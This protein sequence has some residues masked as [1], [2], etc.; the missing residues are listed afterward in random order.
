MIWSV[1]YTILNGSYNSF[2]LNLLKGD[3]QSIFYFIFVY[4]QLVLLTPLIT[5]LIKS[6]YRY[7]GYFIT[8]LSL[9]VTRYICVFLN[10]NIRFPFDETFFGN[11]FI[12]YYIGILLG[13]NISVY[14]ISMRKT[15]FLYSSAIILS[16]TEGFLWYQAGNYDLATTQLRLTSVITSIIVILIFYLYFTNETYKLKSN[17]VTNIL[18]TMGNCSF[19]IYLSHLLINRI[20]NKIPGYDILPFPITSIIL[21]IVSTLFVFIGHKTLGNKVSKY[22]GL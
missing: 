18:I 21:L 12:F 8:P 14:K 20:L 15:L 9:F 19:G 2:V 16:E 3:C 1:I 10:I 5:K 13:N 22:V 4:I 11:W 7:I 17:T 6:K